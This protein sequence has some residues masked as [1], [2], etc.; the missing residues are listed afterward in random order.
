[1]MHHVHSITC[2]SKVRPT[3]LFQ[4]FTRGSLLKQWT[5]NTEKWDLGQ[6]WVFAIRHDPRIT[7]KSWRDR[8][9]HPKLKKHA[10]DPYCQ[11]VSVEILLISGGYI[12]SM[13]SYC[14]EFKKPSF[15]TNLLTIR[16]G[17][18]EVNFPS[19]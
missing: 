12:C 4:P 7:S 2:V 16:L 6:I 9:H 8:N 18:F 19:D 3:F 10:W 15:Q 11:D 1:M 5:E 13:L 17:K 14:Y